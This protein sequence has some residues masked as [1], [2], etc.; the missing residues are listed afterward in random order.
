MDAQDA[1]A[2]QFR[3][4]CRDNARRQILMVENACKVDPSQREFLG[5]V[6]TLARRDLAKMIEPDG[7]LDIVTCT[8]GV[9]LRLPAS[10]AAQCPK[11][12]TRWQ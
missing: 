7:S 1:A 6:I 9:K 2:A 3:R 12:K 4:T 5:E 8:C 10:A 11:C